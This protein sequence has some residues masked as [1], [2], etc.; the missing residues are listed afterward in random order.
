MSTDLAK[1]ETDVLTLD[2]NA[3]PAD[4]LVQLGRVKVAKGILRAIETMLEQKGMEIIERHGPIQCGDVEYAICIDKTEKPR[5]KPVDMARELVEL[6]G[7]DW[8][9]F[10]DCLASGAFKHGAIKRL[11]ETMGAPERF[12]EW[13]EQVIRK[14]VDE[15]PIKRVKEINQMFVK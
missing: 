1:I 10:A 6:C 3:T 12:R 15:K 14:G 4:Y 7:G 9:A 2:D 11:C 13:F 5:K 8:D